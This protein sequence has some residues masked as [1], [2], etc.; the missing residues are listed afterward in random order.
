MKD[1]KSMTQRISLLGRKRFGELS[2]S[3]DGTQLK[4]EELMTLKLQEINDAAH[5]RGEYQVL[6]LSQIHPD[7]NQPRKMFRNIESLAASIREQ[8][9]IQ[10]IIVTPKQAD[11][12]Y[13]IIAGERR[14]LAAQQ[15]GLTTV[16]CIVRDEDDANIVI[17]QL[18]EN[19]QRESVSPLEE[20][21]ALAKL[22][23]RMGVSQADIARELGRDVSWVSIRIGLQQ[24]SPEVKALVDDQ[25]VE[26]VRTLHELR[27]L[28]T[29]H[30]EQAKQLIKRIR[31]NQVSGSY[32]QVISAMREQIKQ[33]RNI[34]PN[35]RKVERLEK[36][37]DRLLI[38]YAGGK[39]P[40]E[41]EVAPDVLV[42]FLA[43]VTYE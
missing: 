5:A 23:D 24:V 6:P 39:H 43:G 9:V 32:R 35:V 26:D 31:R 2:G 42:R 41:F 10:P 18:L 38:Y 40:L 27:M 7:P 21:G 28:E 30:P 36:V 1:W 25:L 33:K 20:S 15:A 22:V 4:K 19:D 12:L 13:R 3:E 17:L 16:P 37:G 8:G 34:L 11:G 29:E 14:F